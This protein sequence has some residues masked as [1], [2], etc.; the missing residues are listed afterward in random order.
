[1]RGRNR[2]VTA[3]ADLIQVKN[4][5]TSFFTPEG[6]VRAI[7]GI[8]F[9]IGEGKTLGLVGESGCGKSVTSLSIMRLIQSPPGKIVGGEIL[10]RGKDLLKL[11]NEAMR[12]IR[13]NEISMIF[14]EPM[15]SLNPVF[16]VGNQIG[17]AIKLHQGLGKQETRAKTIEML[18]LVKIADPE[19]RVDSYPHQLSGG[20]RQRVMIAMALSCN[21]S[22]LIADEPTTA[23]DV[24]IQAQILELMKELQ[25]K[26][27]GMAL[28]L[29]THD[30]GVV[31]EQAD[32]VAIMYAGK[33]VE[34]AN[35]RAIFTKPFHPYTV[36]LLNSL[37]SVGGAKKHRLDAIPGVVPSPLHLPSGCRF[38][39]RCPK[40]AELCAQS[41]PELVEREAG[42]TVACHFPHSEVRQS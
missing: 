25:R 19:S 24:T 4:L 15:T 34:R 12:K 11:N 41:E 20:M 21:P 31:A 3:M 29:I 5:Q 32:D 40:A 27:G 2:E 13:G 18:R 6:E 36:G 10:Y 1:V 39:D 23:L 9:E 22:L 26:I 42:H 17:E 30:L 33:I 14:Q 7:D 37:P 35:T 16:T 38:R 28:L 8:S